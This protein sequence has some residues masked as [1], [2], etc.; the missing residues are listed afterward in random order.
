M[1][2]VGLL[3]GGDDS[4]QI[5]GD[6]V[7]S[8]YL[9][10][11]FERAGYEVWRAS[12]TDAETD[13][14]AVLGE[15]TDLVIAHGVP[16]WQVPD[17]V[18][19]AS[20]YVVFWWLSRLFY[21]EDALAGSRFHA[22]ATNATSLSD[23]LERR[24]VV[25]RKIEL[26]SPAEFLA[27]SP[28]DEYRSGA[29]YVGCYPH[30]IA[31]QLELLLGPASETGLAIWGYGWEHSPYSRWHRGVLPLEDI[32]AA[33]ASADVVLGLTE[34][35][36]A[37]IGMLNNRVFEALGA[38]AVVVADGFPALRQ[39]EVGAYVQ[40]VESPA[41]AREI[42]GGR[43]DMAVLREAA[44]AGREVVRKRHTYDHRVV[45]FSELYETLSRRERT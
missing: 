38:G 20:R 13:W 31:A 10:R 3:F 30:K 36:Q 43:R 39:H 24:G 1:R 34:R 2:R 17:D 12:S 28:R 15:P 14:R 25:S 23:V 32:G 16:E 40:A 7:V 22:V 29:T 8:W 9:A 6:A 42:L 26:A 19:S 18:W 45:E 11:A 37:A 44:A 41:E 4:R 27:A 35:R 21:D 33:Y 5:H